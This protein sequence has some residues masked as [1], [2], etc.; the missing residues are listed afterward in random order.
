ML[1]QISTL[2]LSILLL[3]TFNP[4][5]SAFAA[6]SADDRAS[7]NSKKRPLLIAAN[8][9]AVNTVNYIAWLPDRASNNGARLDAD[10]ARAYLVDLINKDRASS[11]LQPVVLDNAATR[12]GQSHC[13]EMALAQYLSHWDLSGRKPDQRYSEAGGT[14]AVSEN[15]ALTR[16]PIH[17][18]KYELAKEQV[19]SK[20]ELE[21][22]ESMFFNEKPPLDGHRKNILMPAHNKV[23]IGLARVV[24]GGTI[25]CTEEFVNEYASFTQLPTRQHVGQPIK[26]VGM[27]PK[28]VR[29]YSVDVRY[30]KAAEPMTVRQLWQTYSYSY[31]EDHIASYYPKPYL[32]PQP[33]NVS[34]IPQGEKFELDVKPQTLSKPGLYYFMVWVLQNALESPIMTL[35]RTVEVQ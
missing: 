3:Q 22:I 31:P 13:E 30:E 29:V 18:E 8:V 11:R 33:I 7:V 1:R 25:T 28:G 12:A 35:S 5:R 15:A 9:N 10:A 23:G 32:S 14:G 16:Y 26:L 6:P 34:S 24:P 27:V 2:C 17:G 20:A 21:S 19:F 4:S